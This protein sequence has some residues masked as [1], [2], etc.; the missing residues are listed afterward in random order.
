MES[1]VGIN[2]EAEYDRLR[3]ELNKLECQRVE[4]RG[5]LEHEI[6]IRDKEIDILK[7]K[8]S[9]VELIFSK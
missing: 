2:Y 6:D 9:I 1:K 8:L 5:R 7:A 3:N 4:E